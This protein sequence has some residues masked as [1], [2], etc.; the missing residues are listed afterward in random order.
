M[1]YCKRFE[2]LYQIS[3]LILQKRSVRRGEKEE[4]REVKKG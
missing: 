1:Y 3:L 2:Y 4:G